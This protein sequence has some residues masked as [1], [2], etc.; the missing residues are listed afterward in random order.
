ML[1]ETEIKGICCTCKS[2]FGCLSLNNS[3]KRGEPILFCESFDD[4][5]SITN[6]DRKKQRDDKPIDNRVESIAGEGLCLNCDAKPICGFPDSGKNVVYCE[7][8]AL[9]CPDEGKIN[10]V[11]DE[12]GTGPCF[13]I[14]E[15]I[16]GEHLK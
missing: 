6:S 5:E 13:G 4:S 11:S 15:L 3:L 8:H 16:S 14:K 2:R 9:G 1:Q 10:R 7:E 12:F